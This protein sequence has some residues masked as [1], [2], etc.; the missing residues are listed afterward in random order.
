[1]QRLQPLA[2]LALADA[3]VHRLAREGEHHVAHVVKRVLGGGHNGGQLVVGQIEPGKLHAQRLHHRRLPPFHLGRG[4]LAG[5]QVQRRGGLGLGRLRALPALRVG[6]GLGSGLRRGRGGRGGRGG[7]QHGG[8]RVVGARVHHRGQHAQHLLVHRGGDRG[9]QLGRA[10]HNGG[11]GRVAQLLGG[12]G[13]LDVLG[14][15]D[16]GIR[17]VAGLEVM[18]LGGGDDH[19]HAEHHRKAQRQRQ[20]RQQRARAEQRRDLPAAPGGVSLVQSLHIIT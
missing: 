12:D 16:G 18:P 10:L 4:L 6:G 3:L 20:H 19:E 14:G 8:G 11:G 17:D 13:V 9:V 15:G 2:Q 1:M 7:G 5:R